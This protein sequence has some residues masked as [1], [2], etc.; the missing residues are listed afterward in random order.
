MTHGAWYAIGIAA[1]YFGVVAL[2]LLGAGNAPTQ[3][4]RCEEKKK[5][6]LVKKGEKCPCG[7]ENNQRP[8]KEREVR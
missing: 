4:P 6:S 2:V 8:K 3:C 5:V 1:A 7:W